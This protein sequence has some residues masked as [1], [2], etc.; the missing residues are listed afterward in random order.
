MK[1]ISWII[2]GISLFLIILATSCTK[3]SED[4]IIPDQAPSI[5]LQNGTDYVYRNDTFTVNT[6]IK[7]GIRAF[8]NTST[9]ANLVDF[10]FSRT[11]GGNTQ[12]FDSVFSAATFNV[13]LL[14]NANPQ[15]GIETFI[16]TVKDKNG[17][18]K[19]VTLLITTNP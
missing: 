8:A 17:K 19:A 10:T 9:N 3:D 4:P 18:M 11:L 15:V 16:F 13:D 7:I 12:T 14:T 5:S 2:A 1:K 6:P